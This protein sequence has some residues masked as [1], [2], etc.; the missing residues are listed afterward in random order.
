MAMKKSI[1]RTFAHIDVA[2]NT[3][4]RIHEDFFNTHRDS[5]QQSQNEIDSAKRISRHLSGPILR[6]GYC[7]KTK[8]GPLTFFPL[9]AT[10]TSTRSAILMKGM[11]LFIPYCLRSKAIIPLTEPEPVPFPDTVSVSFSGL[12]TPRIVKSP[13]T[14]KVS[15]PVWIILVDL[16]V[17]NGLCLTSKKSLPFSFPFFMPL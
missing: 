4:V 16:N 2:A 8:G 9:R 11:P 10:L 7:L 6:V 17:I 13:S 12:V 1:G 5:H 15:G 3:S 14:S